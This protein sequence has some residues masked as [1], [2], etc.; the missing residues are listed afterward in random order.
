M[1]CFIYIIDIFKEDRD[2]LLEIYSERK[3]ATNTNYSQ[4]NSNYILVFVFL[5]T[6]LITDWNRRAGR[7][8][9][10]HCWKGSK[11]DWIQP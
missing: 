5:A 4:G 9:C 8:R 7:W 3:E 2:K 10:A 1:V 6:R 11:P